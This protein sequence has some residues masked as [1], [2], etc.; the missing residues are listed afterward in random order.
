[1]NSS[2][3]NSEFL[4][5]MPFFNFSHAVE[6]YGLDFEETSQNGFKSYLES[7]TNDYEQIRKTFILRELPNCRKLLHKLKGVFK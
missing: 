7:I 3:N 4:I 2:S 5:N 1:M 6:E